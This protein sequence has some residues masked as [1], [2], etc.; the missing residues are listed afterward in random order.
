MNGMVPFKFPQLT[1]GNFDNWAIQMKALFGLQ[2][3]E[4]EGTLTPTQKEAL[5]KARKKD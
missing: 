2:D 4:N 3:A 5:V 1:K